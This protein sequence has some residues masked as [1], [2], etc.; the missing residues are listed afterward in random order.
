[1]LLKTA[2]GLI[3][4]SAGRVLY[5][6][7]DYVTLPEQDRARLQT[8]TGFQFQDAALWANL[9][10]AANLDLPLQAKFP[11]LD[12][13]ARNRRLAA[14]IEEF[15]VPLDPTRRPVDFSLGE[16]KLISFLRAVIPGPEALFLDEPLAWLDHGLADLIREQIAALRDRGVAIILGSHDPHLLEDLADSLIVLEDGRLQPRPPGRTSSRA[17]DENSASPRTPSPDRTG[18]EPEGSQ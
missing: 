8:R 11:R 18:K 10:V 13:R 6:G 1:M 3:P 7:V 15:G 5:D 4:P 16:Q 17:R 12:R 2:A 14:A 9:P